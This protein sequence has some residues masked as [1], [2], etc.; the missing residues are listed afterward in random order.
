MAKEKTERKQFFIR[1]FVAIVSGIILWAWAYVTGIVT[2]FNYI[3]VLFRG[4]RSKNL[5][6]FCEYWVAEVVCFYRYV[7][8]I[9]DEKPFPFTKLKASR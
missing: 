7:A 5:A 3:V 2:V 8:F 6:D 4:R 1:I 9:K